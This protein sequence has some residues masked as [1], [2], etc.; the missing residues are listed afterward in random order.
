MRSTC[1]DPYARTCTVPYTTG[2]HAVVYMHTCTVAYM[3]GT[4]D[5]KE[6]SSCQVSLGNCMSTSHNSI[7][8]Q[9]WRKVC[10]Q[11]INSTQTE[12]AVTVP[13][14]D[15]LSQFHTSSQLS[16]RLVTTFCT[17]YWGYDGGDSGSAIIHVLYDDTCI[18][19]STALR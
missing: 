11:C 6:T 16:L 15:T 17:V 5:T 7:G 12:L 3:T 13:D 1:P 9:S 19:Y 4:H 2:A 18:R 14:V 8:G 10:P